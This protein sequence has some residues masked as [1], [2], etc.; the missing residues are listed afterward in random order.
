MN[1]QK[2]FK[3]SFLILKMNSFTSNIKSNIINK[4]IYIISIYVSNN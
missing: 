4:I 2:S 3:D 1:T